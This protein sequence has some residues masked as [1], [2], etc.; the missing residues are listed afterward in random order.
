MLCDYAVNGKKITVPELVSWEKVST[1]HAVEQVQARLAQTAV[2]LPSN[3]IT[4]V[5]D[6]IRKEIMVSRQDII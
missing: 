5:D 2:A 6:G 3:R 1:E 4:L